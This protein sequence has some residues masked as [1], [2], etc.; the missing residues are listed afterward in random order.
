MS[1][2]NNALQALPANTILKGQYLVESCVGS[3]GFGI[4]Y[5]AKNLKA[6]GDTVAIKEYFPRAVVERGE[7]GRVRI[8]P[9]SASA[10]RLWRENYEREY[11]LLARLRDNRAIARVRE[12]FRENDT[13]YL[14][15]DFI[16]G[17]TLEAE[18]RRAPL[19]AQAV[20][21][22]LRPWLPELAKM[23]HAGIL[24]RDI[25]PSNVM[26]PPGD[27]PKL[28]DFGSARPVPREG[29]KPLTRLLRPGFAPPEQYDPAA[30]QGPETDVYG[31]CATLYYALTGV[32]PQAASDRVTQDA[33][34]PLARLCAGPERLLQAVEKGMM[35]EPDRRPASFEA[36]WQEIFGGEARPAEKASARPAAEKASAR[37]A[38]AKAIPT[39]ATAPAG[40]HMRA[41]VEA[42]RR[43]ARLLRPLNPQRWDGFLAKL[44]Q[45][46]PEPAAGHT[47][48]NRVLL[49]EGILSQGRGFALLCALLTRKAA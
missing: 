29:D 34:A 12:T 40:A 44:D 3:G 25:N 36:L 9:E 26:L 16:P 38:A 17:H 19:S 45:W 31:L 41:R 20:L 15:M 7:K 47:A 37:P 11:S 21:E 23:H 30:R 49:E 32:V 1:Q 33:L 24:H 46:A 27:M 14:V 39:P 43:A 8:R 2:T 4:T 13:S 5:R 35:L 42:A 28:I 18:A 6:E 10:F 48:M 22:L